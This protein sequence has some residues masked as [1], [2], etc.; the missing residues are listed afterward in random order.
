[1]E[2]WLYNVGY[3]AEAVYTGKRAWSE[4]CGTIMG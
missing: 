3:E 2:T 1:M 4:P